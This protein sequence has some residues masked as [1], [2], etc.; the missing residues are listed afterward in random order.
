MKNKFIEIRIIHIRIREIIRFYILGKPILQCIQI[1][2]R[3]KKRL[4]ISFVKPKR[5]RE[6]QRIFYLKVNRETDTA[7]NSIQQWVD[8]A[9]EMNSFIYFVCDNERFRKH[10][11]N[12]IKFHNDNFRFI[13]SDRKTLKPEISKLFHN[14]QNY[15]HWQRVAY[16]MFTPFLDAAKNNY[17][18]TYNIDGDDLILCAP[19]EKIS[20]ALKTAE[21]YAINNN[22]DLFNLDLFVSRTY[23]T[24]WSFGVVI[25]TNPDKC[26][27]VIRK[28]ISWRN[29]TE[30]IK[31]YKLI[32]LNKYN[33]N[34][35]WLFTFL[36]D[37]EQL[38]VQTFYIENLYITHEPDKLIRPG[39]SYI[40][41][42]KQ[43]KIIYP[44]SELIYKNKSQ[45]SI[46]IYPTSIKFD[47]GLKDDDYITFSN[48]LFD[49]NYLNNKT[50]MFKF[51]KARGLLNFKRY[52]NYKV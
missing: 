31:K 17:A 20:E 45:S 21:E 52:E 51:A 30:M 39:W 44:F 48:Y 3:N 36:R 18:I 29:N 13:E 7:Y 32:Y 24:H 4:L 41:Q 27:N 49:K 14:T 6:G 40:M 11:Y 37:T 38:N 33:F 46:P 22:L 43:D 8:I 35:D 15:K 9:K 50:T 34:A 42:Y 23:G 47:I 25:C 28:N 16:S 1:F 10:I 2:K 26:L 19:P 5:P 12:I